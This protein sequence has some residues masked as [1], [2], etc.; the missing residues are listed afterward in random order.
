MINT[1]RSFLQ[2]IHPFLYFLGGFTV[3][4]VIFGQFVK[5]KADQ[6]NNQNR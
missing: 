5:Y 4:A 1:I 2:S 6:L 3:V